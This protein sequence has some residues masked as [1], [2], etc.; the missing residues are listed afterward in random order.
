MTTERKRHRIVT[1]GTSYVAT[2]SRRT[3]RAQRRRSRQVPVS[4]LDNDTR[5]KQSRAVQGPV[6]LL[7]ND[8]YKF[9]MGNAVWQL[10]E[11]V[12]VTY[13]FIDRR[14]EG[15][16]TRS[17]VK[18]LRRKIR[19][20]ANLALTPEEKSYCITNLKWISPKYWEHLSNYRYDPSEVKVWLDNENNLQV[21]IK[22]LWHRTILWEV[23]LLALISEVY[24]AKIDTSWSE[25]GQDEKMLEKAKRLFEKRVLWAD[26]GTRR[27]RHL[28]S[29]ERVVRTAMLFSNFTGTSNVYLAMKYGVK[30]LGTMAHEWPMAHSALFGLPH[31]NK[32]A[33]EAWNHVYQGALGTALPDT[34]G[35]K[36]FLRDF[37]GL[38][39]RCFDSVRHDSGDPYEWAE[40]FIAHYSSP[41]VNIKWQT[42]PFGFTDGNTVDS[43]IEIHEW[44][45]AKGGLCWFGIGTH[46][47]NDYGPD[48]PACNIVIKLTEVTDEDG[49]STEVVKL[50]DNPQKASG[51]LEAIRMAMKVFHGM[52]LDHPDHAKRK[53]P[54][55]PVPANARTC[56]LPLKRA[57]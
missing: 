39:A 10:Y 21:E 43:A 52:P 48:S 17:E 29:Q 22:G 5:R 37:K 44:M 32:Y 18:L 16:W 12:R 26:F 35:T 41:E 9:S 20:M 19:E 2:S 13:R 1:M 7:D 27:R 24:F 3:D 36:A 42:K 56:A 25:D 40:M 54:Y 53:V 57:A 15:K 31:A 23:P 8:L 55:G 49:K 30:A 46:M 51:D 33:L 50:S 14:A 47:S 11:K 4:L 45:T 38:L 34:F 6:S 28:E